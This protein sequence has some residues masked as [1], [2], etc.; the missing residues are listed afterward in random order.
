MRDLLWLLPRWPQR[1]VLELAPAYFK[2]ETQQKFDANVFR[3]VLG[4]PV[5]SANHAAELH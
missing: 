5:G 3:V 4:L 1:R 2:R